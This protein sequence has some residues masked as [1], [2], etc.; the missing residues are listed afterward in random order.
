MWCRR[1]FCVLAVLGGTRGEHAVCPGEWVDVDT[2]NEA[3]VS[4]SERDGARL[5]LVFSDEFEREGR[6]FLDGHDARWTGLN[7]APYSNDQVNYYNASKAGTRR[8]LL[9]LNSTYEAITFVTNGTSETRSYQTAM[10]QTWNKFCFQQGAVEVSAKMPGNTSSQVGL[11]PAF[12][13]M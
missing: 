3:C 4:A 1:A 7:S 8:G 11:W 12:W 2:P 13:L 9:E 5:E 10:L 6:T